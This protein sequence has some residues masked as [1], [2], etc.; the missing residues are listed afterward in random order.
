MSSQK[1]RG[2]TLVE[3]LVVIAI[4]GILIALLLPAIQAA[5][6]AARRSQC[7]NNLK[8]MGTASLAHLSFH[9]CF[10]SGGWGWGWFGDPDKGFGPTQP[11]G[12]L[13]SI[14]PYMEMKQLHNMGR[15]TTNN[16]DTDTVKKDRSR[17]RVETPVA[18]YNC[19]TRRPAMAYPF[20]GWNTSPNIITPANCGKS[21]YAANSFDFNDTPYGPNSYAAAPTFPWAA[22]PG[23]KG[24]G[25]SFLRSK[26]RERDVSDGLSNTFLCGEK[27]MNPDA[28]RVAITIGDDQAW[29]Q[30]YDYDNFRFIHSG[31]PN[32]NALNANNI[33][34]P[35]R[36][37]PGDDKVANFGSAHPQT[38]NMEMCDGSVHS[39]R[40]DVNWLVFFRFGMRNDRGVHDQSE[41]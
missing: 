21:D 17:I 32:L 8:Q 37:R 25:V 40:Y 14:L 9:K 15:G 10:P 33:Y 12:W 1:S 2:F 20:G 6:E 35:Y 39:L 27:Y 38:F 18:A 34:L 13:Y 30:A 29:D 11:G 19:P 31:T 26:V 16:P 24:L 36:D 3:L 22:Q 41:W 28:Y 5:R 4:I 7:T 23:T